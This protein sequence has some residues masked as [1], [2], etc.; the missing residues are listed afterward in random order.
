MS[1]RKTRRTTQTR[2]TQVEIL[3]STPSALFRSARTRSGAGVHA[4]QGGRYG[5]RER[6]KNRAEERTAFLGD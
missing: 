3:Q 2:R 1:G 4:D 5:K 6:A